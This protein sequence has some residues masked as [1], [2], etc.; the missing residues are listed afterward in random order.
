MEGINM[1]G[2]IDRFTDGNKAV[3]LI[4][5]IGKEIVVSQKD[6]PQGAKPHDWVRLQQTKDTFQVISIDR[7]KTAA[8]KM[9]VE[10]LKAKLR[11]KS[12][13]SK[14]KKN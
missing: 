7:E 14:F 12:R 6:L 10:Q 11:A 4:E 3:I 8:Q 9:K 13:G 1:Q 2:V 5:S